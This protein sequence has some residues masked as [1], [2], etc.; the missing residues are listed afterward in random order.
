MFSSCKFVKIEMLSKQATSS[1][2]AVRLFIFGRRNIKGITGPG[3]VSDN[4]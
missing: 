3:G 4:V 2:G 1:P